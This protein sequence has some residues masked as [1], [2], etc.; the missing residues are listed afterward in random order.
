MAL[1]EDRDPSSAQTAESVAPDVFRLRDTCNVYVLRSGRTA[2]LIDFGSGAV[3]D[4]LPAL[5]VDRVTDVLVTHHHRDQ[6]QG[7]ARAVAAG[8]RVWVPP[9]E[10]D[11]IAAVDRHWLRRPIDNDYDLRQDRFSLLDPVPVT[12]TA[13]EYRTVRYGD[14]DVYTLPTPGHTVGSVTYLVELDGRRLA[15]TGDLVYGHGKV[16]SLAATQWTYTGVEGQAATILACGDLREHAPDVLL[17]SH[18]DPI[19]DPRAAISLVRRRLHDLLAMRTDRSWD[20]DDWLR[21][22]WVPVTPHLL[23]NRTSVA[24]SWALL[25]ESGAALLIDY[26]YDMTT[27]FTNS[28][29][30]SARRPLLL[31]LPAL[32]RDFGVE[33]IEV[34]IPTHYHDDHVAGMNLLRE[35]EDVEIWAPQNV[36]PVLEEPWRFDLPCLWYDPIPVDRALEPGVPVRWREYELTT[37]ALPGHSFFAAAILFEVD[38]RR[39][40]ATGD[41]QSGGG[42]PDAPDVLNYQYRNRFRYDDFTRS[43]QLYLALKP[44]ILLSGHRAPREVDEKYLQ[45]LLDDGKRLARLHRELLPVEDVDFGA[46]GFGARIEPYR[47]TVKLGEE[48]EL[49]LDVRNPF[50]RRSVASVRFVVPEGWSAVPR[51]HSVTLPAHAET[52]IRFRVSPDGAPVGRA[53]IAA[54]LSV[55]DM[56]F[57]QQAEALVNVE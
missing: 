20:L 47:S 16:W 26:G 36:V 50:A 24:T 13:A 44:D 32:R 33:R 38:G 17:P 40:L 21:R 35:A 6:V 1:P 55:G 8:A 4:H 12:G 7:L 34:A 9:V 23:R 48:L 51:E 57:G 25:S 42:T 28:T 43:A 3:L 56:R 45:R 37:Y 10:K 19:E 49:E 11:L 22:P 46:E 29:D 2:V 5:G 53:R 41:Q 18:G 15:F 31:S 54:D 27:G 39:V 52:K 30:R 14:F